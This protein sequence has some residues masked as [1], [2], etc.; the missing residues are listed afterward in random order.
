MQILKNWI[1]GVPQ[2]ALNGRSFQSIEPATGRP[3]AQV[4]D[5]DAS[6]VERAITAAQRAFPSWSDR[7]AAERSHLLHTVAN[8][9]EARF[10]EFV[11]AESRDN[12]KPISLARNVDIPRAIANLRFFANAILHESSEFHRAGTGNSADHSWH[13][14]IRRPIGV[15][16]CIS[17]WNLPLYLFTWKIA[18]ALA[19][20]CT[21]VGKPSELTPLTAHLLGEVTEEVGFPAG[22]LNIVHGLG[23]AAGQPIVTHPE[24]RAISFT[25][26]TETGAT[27]AREAAPHFKKLSLELG[28]KNPSIVFADADIP[29]A[30]AGTIR[31]GFTNQGEIC[32]CGSRLLVEHSIFDEFVARFTEGVK[33]LKVGDPNEPTTEIG[34]LISEDHLQKVSHFVANAQEEGGE[35]LCGGSR[36]TPEGRCQNGSFFEPTVISA[37]SPDCRIQQEEVF[38]PVVSVIPFRDEAEALEIA[39]GVRYGL[40]ASVWTNDLS[41]SHRFAEQLEAGIIWFNCWMLR[42][43][44]VPFGG[45]KQSG[46]GREGG[47]DALRFFTEP[48]SVCVR[49]DPNPEKGER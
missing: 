24:T 35:I 32:L 9:I 3:H 2:D 17:P 14:T 46:V 38:G 34:A 37:P 43:L 39:N 21:V 42:D 4:P 11:E 15:V 30:I 16:G 13:T 33:A 23:A 47:W 28:G 7:A 12:G 25:G 29:A 44:R 18:P 22:V 41:R 36:V 19:A 8:G 40:A 45:L 10:D 20:G 31:A 6:D 48:K 27:I 26:G 5:S 49:F 1:D